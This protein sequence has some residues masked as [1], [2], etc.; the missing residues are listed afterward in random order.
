M[1]VIDILTV[2][3]SMLSIQIGDCFTNRPLTNETCLAFSDGELEIYANC[4]VTQ[5]EIRLDKC[6]APFLKILID[7][8]VLNDSRS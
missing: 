6:Q 3:P 2:V 4:D 1:K 5:I 7:R 8:K